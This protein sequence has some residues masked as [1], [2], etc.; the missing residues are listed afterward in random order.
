MCYIFF[1]FTFLTLGFVTTTSVLSH[2]LDEQSDFFDDSAEDI[3]ISNEIFDVESTISGVIRTPGFN[4]LA[5]EEQR[6]KLRE[7]MNEYLKIVYKRLEGTPSV[8]RI[9]EAAFI[10]G[11]LKQFDSNYSDDELEAMIKGVFAGDRDEVITTHT[12]RTATGT[13]SES[14]V[15]IT[16][17]DGSVTITH[18]EI[19]NGNL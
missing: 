5:L 1:I 11:M 13:R 15:T 18:T 6:L 3:D 19:A 16:H 10:Q 8:E 17:V 4:E 2:S 9:S 7:A 12:E 14:T